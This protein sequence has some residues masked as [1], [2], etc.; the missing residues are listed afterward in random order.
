MRTDYD[1]LYGEA[2][3]ISHSSVIAVR[4][5]K[6]A[7]GRAAASLPVRALRRARRALRG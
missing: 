7:A 5:R 2:E 1:A 4:P 3:A 6:K